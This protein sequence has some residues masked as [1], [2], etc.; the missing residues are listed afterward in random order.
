MRTEWIVEKWCARRVQPR[1]MWPIG[2]SEILRWR[3]HSPSARFPFYFYLCAV[4]PVH[5]LR[6]RC[7]SASDKNEILVRW[8]SQLLICK[9]HEPI[10]LCVDY[11]SHIFPES[12]A[13]LQLWFAALLGSLECMANTEFNLLTVFSFLFS[14][15]D[16]LEKIEHRNMI[17]CVGVRDFKSLT[18]SFKMF[19]GT[20]H[21]VRLDFMRINRIWHFRFNVFIEN[22]FAI[23]RQHCVELN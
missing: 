21:D 16:L 18:L 9:S 14:P 15:P 7:C 12:F 23:A 4:W 20:L 2:E 22:G 11:Y 13:S 5:V 19:L 8:H 10:L 1:Q 17:G 3:V 6:C